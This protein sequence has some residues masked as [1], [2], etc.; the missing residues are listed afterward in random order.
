[1]TPIPS[2]TTRKLEFQTTYA[3]DWSDPDKAGEDIL[4]ADVDKSVV[5]LKRA[6]G[7]ADAAAKLTK[8]TASGVT[9]VDGKVTALLLPDDTKDLQGTYYAT[10]RLFMKSGAVLDWQDA[11]GKPYVK[12]EFVQG[13]VEATAAG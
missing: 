5:M 7:T 3:S 8:T 11:A 13:A 1:M 9:V 12:L 4:A 10:C 6:L 2:G